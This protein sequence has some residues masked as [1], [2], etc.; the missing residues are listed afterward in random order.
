MRIPPMINVLWR[1][2]RQPE[3]MT[4]VE[5]DDTHALLTEYQLAGLP[6]YSRSQPSGLYNGKCWKSI[7]WDGTEFLNFCHDEDFESNRITV[8][9]RRVLIA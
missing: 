2:W 1:H 3:D 9:T 4:D 5:I 6:D 8:S 7:S